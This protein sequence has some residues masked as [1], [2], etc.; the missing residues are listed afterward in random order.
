[1]GVP[2]LFHAPFTES[3]FIEEIFQSQPCDSNGFISA[4]DDANIHPELSCSGLRTLLTELK[5]FFS[6]AISEHSTQF[7][8]LHYETN[9]YRL[10]TGII[11][12]LS[13]ARATLL[14]KINPFPERT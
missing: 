9:R 7:F 11:D 5:P 8:N 6:P 12:G 14:G 1:M 4:K 3:T 13:M 10:I 2:F